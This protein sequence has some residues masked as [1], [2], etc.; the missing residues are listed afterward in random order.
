MTRAVI[1]DL[2]GTLVR[3]G[4]DRKRMWALTRRFGKD[5]R[6]AELWRAA[7][8]EPDAR[9][10]ARLFELGASA[11]EV[12]ECFAEIE[13]D[14]RT[15]E[16]FTGA[17]EVLV[18]LRERGL[19]LGLLSNISAPYTPAWR[20]SGLDGLVDVVLFSCDIG[21]VKPEPEAYQRML[22]E[23]GVEA[24]EAVMIGDSAKCDVQGPQSV[25]IRGLLL[26]RAGHWRGLRELAEVPEHL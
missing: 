20:H 12:A 9:L 13:E 6:D 10:R 2:F 19:K 11:D 24:H 25:G 15:V 14:T 22:A 21:A 7:M 16:L 5:R 23:L 17:R 4:R 1:F 8:G 18:A 26:D 3:L